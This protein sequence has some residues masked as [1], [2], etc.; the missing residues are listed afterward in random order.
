MALSKLIKTKQNISLENAYIKII[1]QSGNKE[2]I[3]IR[4]A[5]Y[6]DKESSENGKEFLEQRIYSFV[7]T[8]EE[9]FIKQ[10]YE[11]LKTLEEYKN[12]VDC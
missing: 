2:K 4:V 3:N 1:E 8:L 5:I 10:G 12:S 7:P 11:H 6:K 9:N